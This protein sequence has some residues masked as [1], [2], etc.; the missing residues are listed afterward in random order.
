MPSITSPAELHRFAWLLIPD[1]GK[2]VR[3]NRKKI[4]G[5]QH[6][7][8]LLSRESRLDGC[9]P[10]V[11][12]TSSEGF[13][14]NRSHSPHE[15][16]PPLGAKCQLDRR[17]YLGDEAYLIDRQWLTENYALACTEIEQDIKTQDYFDG[18]LTNFIKNP[19]YGDRKLT[20]E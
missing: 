4:K 8:Y 2:I 20:D 15:H 7:W 10:I 16:F 13:S 14:K 18:V 6:R 3:P 1:E 11:I 12:R 9:V 17:A 5:G 19:W